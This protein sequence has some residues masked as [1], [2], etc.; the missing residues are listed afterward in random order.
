MKVGDKVKHINTG[1]YIYVIKK[2]SDTIAVLQ[3]QKNYIHL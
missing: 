3:S 2:I 1:D